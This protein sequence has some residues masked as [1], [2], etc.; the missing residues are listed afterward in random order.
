M[1]KL[2]PEYALA[3]LF[4]CGS[5]PDHVADPNMAAQAVVRWLAASGFK[6]VDANVWWAKSPKGA[7][8]S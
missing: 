5:F 1:S 3:Q 8:P 2:T 4:E 7:A 6:I